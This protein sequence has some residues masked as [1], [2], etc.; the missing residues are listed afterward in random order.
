MWTYLAG[1]GDDIRAVLVTQEDLRNR[2]SLTYVIYRVAAL[3]EK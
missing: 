2:T 3:P 1:V